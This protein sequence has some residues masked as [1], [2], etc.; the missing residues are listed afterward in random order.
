M[1]R[2]GAGWW[3]GAF[4]GLLLA[5]A[6]SPSAGSSTALVVGVQGDAS[7]AGALSSVRVVA[8][9]GGKTV[10][11]TT[12]PATELPH[13]VSLAPPD[14]AAGALVAV[15]V[16]GY[17]A[18]PPL[19]SPGS[20]E[21]PVIVR[22]AE[23]H[24]VPDREA[25]LRIVLGG[26]CL[27]GVP[28]GPPGAPTCDAPQTCIGGSCQPDAVPAQSLE[29]YTADW[30]TNAPDV[31]KPTNAGPPVVQVG[32]GQ[33]D[34][35]PVTSGQTV[36]ME[37]GPQGGHHVWIAVRQENL[38]QSGSTTTLTSVVPTT[39]L[40][41]PMTSYVFTFDPDEGGFCKLAGLRYQLDAD[42]T[43][44]H[45]FLGQPLDVTVTIQD[46]SGRTAS[47]VAHLNID[48]QLL[49]PSGGTGCP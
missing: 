23:T 41:G 14:G 16:E 5:G 30:A 45:R 9:V 11:D 4:L 49:C 28:G 26:N 48:P 21:P 35:L 3:V 6:C 12:V 31:C 20:G 32:T 8:T 38:K 40:A 1:A 25:L 42:G 24:F 22:T 46:P 36:Q 2:G 18:G 27:A 44:Y 33:T 47:G 10:N 17:A 43:D 19:R 7:I 29:A 37:E 15:R 34:Y 39:G 13:E